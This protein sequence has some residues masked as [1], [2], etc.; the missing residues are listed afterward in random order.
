MSVN[1]WGVVEYRPSPTGREWAR[2]WF[3]ERNRRLRRAAIEFSAVHQQS[4][5]K[6]EERA[7]ERVKKE[8]ASGWITRKL[9]KPT[10]N[11][12][13]LRSIWGVGRE[14]DVPPV[15]PRRGSPDDLS[16]FAGAYHDSWRQ[17][18]PDGNI[19]YDCFG[20]S[21][22]TGLE[23]DLINWHVP[24]KAIEGSESGRASA[25]ECT[26]WKAIGKDWRELFA[27]LRRLGEKYGPE[28]A[29]VFV[30]FDR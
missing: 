15:S 12:A 22:L 4:Y 20:E 18:D 2:Q 6:C 9:L 13:V 16:P 11:E 23:I 30:W 29:R 17:T 1:I 10:A 25:G 8:N 7:T 24:W 28:N 27:E 3:A 21:Y 19:Y 14:G 5:V 26:L